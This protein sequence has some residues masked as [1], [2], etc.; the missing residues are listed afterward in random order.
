MQHLR[1]QPKWDIDE[2]GDD[3]RDFV[4][5]PSVTQLRSW[6][7][8]RT[9]DIK[10]RTHSVGVQ[11]QYSGTVRSIENSQVAAHLTYATPRGY[12]LIWLCQGQVAPS[13]R[14][15][16]APSGGEIWV[17]IAAAQGERRS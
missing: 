10:K 15:D 9:A 11:R 14:S 16:L 4:A 13:R 6:S 17:F 3:L 7:S 1:A 8:T 12:A 2:V 5:T